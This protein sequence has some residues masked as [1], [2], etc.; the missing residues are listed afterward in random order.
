MATN[1]VARACNDLGSGAWFGMALAEAVGSG[2]DGSADG[3]PT[4]AGRRRIPL[5]FAAWAAAVVGAGRLADQNRARIGRQQG[6]AAT[7]AAKTALM[8]AGSAATI[9]AAALD[10]SHRR[11]PRALHSLTALLTGAVLVA[12]ARLSEQQRPSTVARGIGR[13]VTSLARSR[14]S[15]R[16][17][18][19]A[20]AAARVGR[21]H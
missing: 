3:L 21:G 20:R 8:A 5:Q 17:A 13:Q 18:A 15:R 16:S 10:L 12:D 1:S 19:A 7:A 4:R 2:D 14:R 6:V 11:S 9:L